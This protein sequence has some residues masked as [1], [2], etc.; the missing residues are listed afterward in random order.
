MGS[1]SETIQFH[2]IDNSRYQYLLDGFGTALRVTF[3]A[4][5]IGLSLGILIALVR[6][7]YKD[8]RPSKDSPLGLVHWGL[9]K[10][11]S[12][13]VTVIRGTPTTLQLLAMFNIFLVNLDNLEIVAILTFGLNSAAYIS[14]IFRG[15]IQS[16]DPGEREAARSLGLSYIQTSRYI[17][18]PQAFK[19]SLPSLGN[20]IITLFKE[21]SISGFI[22]L[23]DITRASTIIVSQTFDA[24]PA[25]LAS[26]LIYLGVVLLLEKIFKHLEGRTSYDRN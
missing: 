15:G 20:E 12:L 26:A 14:E 5:L 24:V 9:N 8:L 13:F 10:L 25:Y 21:T 18:L 7:S 3:F 4:L 1:L 17:T 2:F 22:G 16:V 11:A 19:I 23:V 6:S